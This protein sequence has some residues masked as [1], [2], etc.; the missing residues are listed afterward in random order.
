MKTYY[1]RL[2]DNSWDQMLMI[3][4]ERQ[5]VDNHIRIPLDWDEMIMPIEVFKAHKNLILTPKVHTPKRINIWQSFYNDYKTQW[6]QNGFVKCLVEN[7]KVIIESLN[8]YW[9]CRMRICI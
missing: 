8:K 4:G 5:P 2:T 9:E 6:D 7:E 1:Y 3:E